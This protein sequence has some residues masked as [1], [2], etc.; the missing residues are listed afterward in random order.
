[1]PRNNHGPMLAQKYD[2]KKVAFPCVVQPKLDGIR[3]L[4]YVT[5]EGIVLRSRDDK[6]IVMPHIAE[7]LAGLRVLEQALAP[8][9][10]LD[11]EL[12]LH[13]LPFQELSGHVRRELADERKQQIEYHIYDLVNAPDGEVHF[14][15]Y[16]RRYTW[17][18]NLLGWR[19]REHGKLRLVPWESAATP[20]E[21]QALERGYVAQGYEGAM[22][23]T[24][25]IAKATKKNPDPQ[26][27]DDFYEA[28]WHGGARRSWFLQKVKTFEDEEGTITGIEEEFDLDGA[29]KGRT[30]KFVALDR[31]GTEFRCSGITDEMKADSWAN[32]GKYIGQTFTFKFFGR[33]EG[34]VPRHPNFKALRPEG[35]IDSAA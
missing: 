24:K 11:G 30:G 7:E 19:P 5:E 25:G 26:P 33:S 21:V 4:A 18:A 20:E 10:V 31:H 27:T 8:G 12:Y 17:L 23:R 32:P 28:Q 22:V 9:T 35:E 1:M 15:S 3:C 34:G 16:D 6:P 2:P 13:G 14:K 29:P